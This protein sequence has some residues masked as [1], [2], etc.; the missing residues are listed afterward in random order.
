M[1]GKNKGSG[2]GIFLKDNM[3][4]TKYEEQSQCT[5]NLETFFAKVTN[6]TK[7]IYFGVVYRPPSAESVEQSINELKSV[8][9]LLPNE[10]IYISG[11]FNVNLLS[12]SLDLNKLE[13]FLF[14]N[15]LTPCISIATHTKPGCKPSCIDN[16]LTSSSNSIIIFGIL[17]P[18]VSH[19]S[20]IFCYIDIN[21]EAEINDKS[22]LSQKYDYSESN[23]SK[24]AN[25]VS[26]KLNDPTLFEID[27]EGFQKFTIILKET[28]DESF[29][30]DT[31]A[32]KSRRNRLV[33][34][35][36]TT[37]IITSIEEK[38]KL[39]NKWKKSVTRTHVTGDLELYTAY[40]NF[41]K[42]LKNVITQ[43]KK[44]Y[45]YKKFQSAEGN[46][47]KTWQLINEL[48]GKKFIVIKPYFLV[49]TNS[50]IITNC[51]KIANEF[52]NY[53]ISIAPI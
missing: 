16:I 27:L 4:F 11:D 45:T 33:N 2:L 30:I 38:S 43:A 40:K 53:F 22:N 5:E 51:R 19:H 34:P 37:G 12:P 13:E 28:M 46:C 47:K 8:L 7:P 50:E 49:N 25:A 18:I 29:K 15:S 26:E 42:K 20:P 52:N 14:S 9:K 36:I 31:S 17:D 41:R 24:F 23:L 44:L 32:L 3:N 6:L 35:W 21:S 48:R 1:E 10:N 39:Y